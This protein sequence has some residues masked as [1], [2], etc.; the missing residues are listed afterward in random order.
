ML[1]VK[2]N[3]NAIVV[4]ELTQD[5]TRNLNSD[6]VSKLVE[7][8]MKINIKGNYSRHEMPRMAL[9]LKLN[10]QTHIVI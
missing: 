2:W 1:Q 5:T 9:F 10:V 6:V 7:Q 8:G 3:T 4:V